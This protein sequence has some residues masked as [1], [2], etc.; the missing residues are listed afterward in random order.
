MRCPDKRVVGVVIVV[1]AILIAIALSIINGINIFGTT[2]TSKDNDQVSFEKSPNSTSN[3]LHIVLTGSV[4][5]IVILVVAIIVLR[6]MVWQSICKIE[7]N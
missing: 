4:M 5:G 7:H 1:I 6:V 3:N 2:N